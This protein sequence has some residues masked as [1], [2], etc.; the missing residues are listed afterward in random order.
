MEFL[1]YELG[2]LLTRQVIYFLITVFVG[3][4]L[5]HLSTGILNFHKRSFGKA[6]GTVIIGAV[7][8][9]IL[10]FIPYVGRIIGLISFWY[11]IKSFYDVSWGKAI[12]AWI[13]SI[14]VAF[15]IAAVILILCDISIIFIPKL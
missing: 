11:F 6:A 15:I 9:S 7:A 4:F 13:M 5:L 14:L 8:M 10:A 1:G 3:V 2:E 12:L